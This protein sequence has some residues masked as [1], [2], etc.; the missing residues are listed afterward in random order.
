M[1]TVMG[2]HVTHGCHECVRAATPWKGLL[3]DTLRSGAY[4][5]LCA[6]GHC[7]CYHKCHALGSLTWR[8]SLR[9][10]QLWPL[11]A[12]LACHAVGYAGLPS[13][14]RHAFRCHMMYARGW[15]SPAMLSPKACQLWSHVQCFTSTHTYIRASYCVW[16]LCKTFQGVAV[17]ESS[18]SQNNFSWSVAP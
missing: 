11:H 13:Y 7:M 2:T 17:T 14:V 6:S 3:S 15:Q 8:P 4:G 10:F 9:H 1:G 12:S 5:C 16:K 18:Y